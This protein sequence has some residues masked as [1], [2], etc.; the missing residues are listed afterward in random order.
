MG[1]N[2]DQFL[3]AVPNAPA[4]TPR[5]FG[6]GSVSPTAAR[7]I[8][9]TRVANENYLLD[10]RQKLNDFRDRDVARTQGQ[11]AIGSIAQLDPVNDPDYV[12]KVQGILSRNPQASLD[13]AVN[14]LLKI[15][16]DAFNLADRERQEE[17]EEER[18][19]RREEQN[20][21]R[22]LELAKKKTLTELDIQRE[23]QLQDEIE[24]LPPKMFDKYTEYLETDKLDPRRALNQVKQDAVGAGA[25]E[26]LAEVGIAPDDPS[27]VRI[28][29]DPS[30]PAKGYARLGIYDEKGNVD[31]GKV[32]ALIAEKKAGDVNRKRTDQ[33]KQ[34]A[35][36]ALRAINS[37]LNDID[38]DET[39]KEEL[40]EARRTYAKFLG[41]I[42]DT[43]AT[44]AT[45]ATGATDATGATGA[46]TPPDTEPTDRFIPD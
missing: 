35:L 8:V 32:T 43:D 44:G 30:D 40:R 4:G 23:A 3:D 18:R 37:M 20:E 31:T 25:L 33:D 41:Y 16:G 26:E 19:Q 15:Q 9:T 1:D 28:L 13:A 29:K 27:V 34:D 11:A 22:A 14:N 38:T 7:R 5:I 17:Q 39:E 42:D 36:S 10:T 24:N 46:A 2:I 45:G 12:G 6:G 21:V